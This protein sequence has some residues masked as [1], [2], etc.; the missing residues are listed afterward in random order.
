LKL[1]WDFCR[2]D[3]E[4]NTGKSLLDRMIRRGLFKEG[5][6]VKSADH[7]G[8]LIHAMDNGLDYEWEE[9]TIDIEGVDR[10]Y[11]SQDVMTILG[12]A[13]G[14]LPFK[15]HLSYASIKDYGSDSKQ[16]YCEM[17]MSNWWWW[18]QVNA[19]SA[20]SLQC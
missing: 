1:Q 3:V 14:H 6:N 5:S 10:E 20:L 13:F 4:E 16:L 2:T 9:N 17:W 15:E 12:Y 8:E 7:L 18:Q 11:W 19:P